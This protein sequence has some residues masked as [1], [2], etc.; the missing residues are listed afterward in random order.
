MQIVDAGWHDENSE[1]AG[2]EITRASMDGAVIDRVEW[3]W[4][5]EGCVVSLSQARPH[6]DCMPCSVQLVQ[7]MS[8]V[9]LRG[10]HGS[11]IA[12]L[13]VQMEI[14]YCRGVGVRTSSTLHAL[15][16]GSDQCDY[17]DSSYTYM[18][19]SSHCSCCC[20]NRSSSS[21][22]QRVLDLPGSKSLPSCIRRA[23]Q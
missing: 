12:Q 1:D 5:A 7:A 3:L 4:L 13:G 8:A 18:Y 17:R 14:G 19:Y 16:G 6:C 23:S 10:P 9:L 15:G 22:P 11:W 20:F 2:R 21:L